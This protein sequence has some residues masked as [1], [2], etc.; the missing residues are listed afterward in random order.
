MS[1][2]ITNGT[3]VTAVGQYPA[4]V[5][6]DAGRIA[7]IGANLSVP[8]AEQ[9][10][11]AGLYVLPGAIDPPTHLDTPFGGKYTTV[12]DWRAGTIAAACGG[13][14]TVVDFALQAPGQSLRRAIDGWHAKADGK[15]VIDYGFH[16]MV[17]DL[18]DSVRQEI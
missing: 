2:L 3:V 10:D 11:A 15:S 4:D 13:T 17:Q 14:T 1:S 12:D 18:S 5:L 7:Q 9:I 6:I 8:D 16:A